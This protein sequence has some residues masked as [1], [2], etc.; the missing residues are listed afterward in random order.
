ML[1]KAALVGGALVALLN[2]GCG[3]GL[4]GQLVDWADLA[5]QTADVLRT[6]GIV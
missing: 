1:K 5:M 6:F 3:L 2:S 4:N